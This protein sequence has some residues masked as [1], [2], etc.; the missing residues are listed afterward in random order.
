MSEQNKAIVRRYLEETI[1][2]GNAAALDEFTAPDYRGNMSGVP[3]FDQAMH[4][5]MLTAFRAAFPDLH[6]T[7]DELI[8]EGDKVVSRSTYNGTHRGEFQGIPPTGKTFT[9]GGMNVSR[10]VDGKIVEDW[11]VL[12]M[13][14]MLQQLGVV[15]TPG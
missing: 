11:T 7:I 13:L 8:A 15:P 1:N 3:P 12:D 5:Q 2:Q 14:G 10:I 4:R 6:V 9:I